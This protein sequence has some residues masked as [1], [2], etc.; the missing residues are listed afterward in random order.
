MSGG[1]GRCCMRGEWLS[2]LQGDKVDGVLLT[3]GYAV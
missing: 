2:D 1:L 3:G